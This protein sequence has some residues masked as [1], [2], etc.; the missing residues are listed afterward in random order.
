MLFFLFHNLKK[1]DQSLRNTIC[2][3][4]HSHPEC[5]FNPETANQYLHN[6]LTTFN[7]S[8][9]G[10]SIF[11]TIMT[12]RNAYDRGCRNFIFEVAY[13]S[14]TTSW[15]TTD[16]ERGSRELYKQYAIKNSDELFF[17]LKSN[18]RIF[19]NFLFTNTLQL[20]KIDGQ[21]F[22]HKK[23]PM[24]MDYQVINK[25]INKESKIEFK[26]L[27]FDIKDQ[28]NNIEL[29]IDFIETHPDCTFLVFMAPIH[30][31]YTVTQNEKKELLNFSRRVK[32]KYINFINC[33]KCLT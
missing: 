2:V 19:K 25:N 16:P 30:K 29:L 24:I 5:C 1:A 31:S 17:L 10:Q 8:K 28:N 15:K 22:D 23:K 32:I 18:V 33:E 21:F 26:N 14:F 7:L 9:G 13:N 27:H 6:K 11:W 3:F 4:G 20:S 12:S